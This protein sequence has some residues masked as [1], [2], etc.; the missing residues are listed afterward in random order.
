[1]DTF[2][3]KSWLPKHE[4]S[5]SS[6]LYHY[7]TLTGLRGILE[8][9]ALWFGHASSLND[10]LEIQHGQGVV[11]KILNEYMETEDRE[12]I[13]AFLRGIL[14]QVQA[15]GNTMFHTFVACFCESGNLL[16]QW[17]GYANSGG[18][19]CVGIEFSNSTRISSELSELDP[20]NPLFL[21]KVVYDEE[22]Q[23]SL[24]REYLNS[25]IFATKGALD[26]GIS[27]QFPDMPTYPASVMAMQVANVILDM[28]LSFKHPAFKSE[29]EWRLVRVTMENHQPEGLKFRETLGGL[30]PYRP[31]F[32]YNIEEG[33]TPAFPLRS[34]GFGP[35]HEPIRT[36]SA[37][38]LLL[39]HIA[40]DGHA[41]E[42]K[43]PL[44]QIIGAGYSLR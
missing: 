19:Y 43:A 42:L 37:T 15:F 40:A 35:M 30:I 10:P 14:V 21:R 18:G 34:I 6:L 5:D 26:G 3:K 25:A 28:L 2:L 11:G 13:R 24:V 41:I 16:S 32:I 17:R 20:G 33:K 12:D 38:E 31:T 1:M 7:T 29:E 36:R 4:L 22:E 44:V 39:H 23:K 27:D 8:N 9:R